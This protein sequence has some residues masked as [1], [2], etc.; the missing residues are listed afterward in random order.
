[1]NFLRKH[2][3]P[4]GA[5]TIARVGGAGNLTD[6][7]PVR[8]GTAPIGAGVFERL[9]RLQSGV[10]DFF[11]AARTSPRRIAAIAPSVELRTATLR[12][13]R[14]RGTAAALATGQVALTSLAG[15]QNIAW[16]K[17]ETNAKSLT[18]VYGTQGTASPTNGPGARR[19]AVSWSDASGNL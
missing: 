6:V 18:A 1:M 10:C 7:T 16:L 14:L 4:S 11:R 5:G 9:S 3:I 15:A 13:R 17:G 12:G 2:F 8:A 19:G